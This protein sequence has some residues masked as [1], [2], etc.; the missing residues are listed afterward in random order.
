[1]LSSP[2]R[3]ATTIRI[4][5]SAEYCLRVRRRMARTVASAPSFQPFNFWLIFVPFGR[6]DEPEILRYATPSICSVG[7][8]VRQC[9]TILILGQSVAT[10]PRQIRREFSAA[11]ESSAERE[12]LVTDIARDDG[13]D[14]A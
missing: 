6:C 9:N 8:D 4:F 3:P 10:A 5:S 1:M 12:V 13:A 2:R 11:P 7:A 14:N